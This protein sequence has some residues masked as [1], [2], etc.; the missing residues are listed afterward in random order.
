MLSSSSAVLGAG[1]SAFLG[2]AQALSRPRHVATVR[3]APAAPRAQLSNTSNVRL[4]IQGRHLEVCW[5]EDWPAKKAHA[6]THP[7]AR[8]KVT[9]AIKEYTE[10]KFGHAL[11]HFDVSAGS[12]QVCSGRERRRWQRLRRRWEC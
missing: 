6:L 2:G 5:V 4:D 11:S 1:S 7:V 12:H 3:V 10:A 9:P 8:T